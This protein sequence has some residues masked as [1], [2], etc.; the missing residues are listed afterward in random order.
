MAMVCYNI[1]IDDV[2]DGTVRSVLFP[3]GPWR[4]VGELTRRVRSV[5]AGLSVFHTGDRTGVIGTL[6]AKPSTFN[7]YQLFCV[8]AHTSFP[9]TDTE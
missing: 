3:F 6:I 9:F 2:D 5:M 8:L 4:S 7:V 1:Y